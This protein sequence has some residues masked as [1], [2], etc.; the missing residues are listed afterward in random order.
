LRAFTNSRSLNEETMIKRISIA[1]LILLGAITL[2][3]PSY[4]ASQCSGLS[5]SAC[6]SKSS[7]T[8]RKSSV[9]KNG[10]KTKAHCRALPGQAKGSKSKATAKKK[11]TTSKKKTSSK[12]TK[13]KAK[14]SKTSKSKKSANKAKKK[15]KS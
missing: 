10:H 5:S 9:N 11:T 1:L 15:T 3:A 14:K 2:T 7:C 8:W 4:A 6:S 13:T 12:K